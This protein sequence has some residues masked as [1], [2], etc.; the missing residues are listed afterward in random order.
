MNKR[1]YGAPFVFGVEG[2]SSGSVVGD[3]SGQG[4]IAPEGMTWEEWLEEI[5]W[6]YTGDIADAPNPDADRNGDKV[7]DYD[8]YL[9]Y[10]NEGNKH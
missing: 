9:Y 8:D 3:G 2:S 6:G 10:L 1:K 4:S 7:I 5:A